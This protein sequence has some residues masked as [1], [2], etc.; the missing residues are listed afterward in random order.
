MEIINNIPHYSFDELHDNGNFLKR[1]T[2]LSWKSPIKVKH[3]SDKRQAWFNFNELKP[4]YQQMIIAKFGDPNNPLANLKEEPKLLDRYT[5]REIEIALTQFNLV[6]AYRQATDHLPHGKKTQAKREWANV[7]QLGLL[8][9][10]ELD[11]LNGKVSFPSLERWDKLMRDGKNTMDDLLPEKTEKQVADSLTKEQKDYLLDIALGENEL[12]IQEAV[13]MAISAWGF[14]GIN[15][16]PSASRCAKFLTQ[17]RDNNYHLWTFR[18]KGKKAMVDLT[19]PSISRDEDS[20]QFMDLWVADGHTCNFMI[21]NPMTGK[22]CRPTLIVWFDFATRIP[23]GYELM[24]T[25]NTKAVLSAFRNGCLWVGQ[26]LGIE[27]G[28][29]P[30]CVYM[31]NGKSFKNKFFINVP[32]FDDQIIGLFG[33]LKPYGLEAVTFAW[34]YNPQSKPVERFFVDFGGVE[35]QF[36]TYCGLNAL[37]KPASLNREEKWHKGQLQKYINQNGYPTLQGAFSIIRNWVENDFILRP[38]NSKFLKGQYPLQKASGQL[39]AIDLE[40]RTLAIDHFSQMLL[41]EKHCTLSKEGFII[42]GIIYYNEMYFPGKRKGKAGDDYIVKYDI[43]KPEKVWVYYAETGKFWCT[44]GKAVW[45]K[46]HAMA[47]L[48][49]QADQVHH[50]QAIEATQS[51]RK[52]ALKEAKAAGNGTSMEFNQLPAHETVALPEKPKAI[53]TGSKKQ[54]DLTAANTK[55]IEGC[56][57]QLT[58]E[59]IEAE[60]EGMPVELD[61]SG[62]RK[63][64][65]YDEKTGQWKGSNNALMIFSKSAYETN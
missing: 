61:A 19:M 44:A 41:H 32:D 2:L 12:K 63:I 22:L 9:K 10:R 42:D 1:S 35:R 5:D 23:V 51:I 20:V 37:D 27:G 53:G 6:L 43:L 40:K 56:K 58:P 7:V 28:V 26:M 46:V 24:Y 13:R 17:W 21:A 65:F 60:A 54:F 64:L 15:P 14:Q 39:T 31:D 59:D 4:K 11:I 34:P 45:N 62:R 16:I 52:K 36:A 55:A 18:R 3:P 29:L 50:K 33:R 47:K 8:H 38:S 25:E 57:L 30:R 48:G 49:S